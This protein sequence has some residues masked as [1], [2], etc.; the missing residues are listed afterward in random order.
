MERSWR[1]FDPQLLVAAVALTAFGLAMIHSATRAAAATDPRLLDL[2]VARQAIYAAAALAV[3]PLL[4]RFDYRILGMAAPAIYAAAIGLLVVVLFL[5]PTIY[6]SRRWLDLPLIPIQ[7][8]EIA[9][10]ALAIML[11]KYLADQ[12][13]GIRRPLILATTL[14][15]AGVLAILVFLQP[16]A[17]TSLI[18]GAIWLGTVT[19][20]GARPL[21]LGAIVGASGVVLLL[22][23]GI[24]VRPYMLARLAASLNPTSD[25]L[26]VGYNILQ[27]EISVGSGGLLGKGYVQGTQTQLNFLRVQSTDFIFSVLGEELGFVGAIVLFALY[28]WLLMRG[29]RA[30]ML[31]RDEFGRFLAVGI[32]TLIL[33]QA[34]LN[35]SVNVRLL[36]VTGVPLPF[37][38]YGGSSLVTLLLCVGILESIVVRHKKLE[39]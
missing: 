23:Q 7:P 33:A 6:G 31:A 8:S 4:T 20:A 38:S 25:P 32:V 13:E 12:R 5:A 22:L 26:G 17:G 30:A 3:I 29:L 21:H 15:I 35:I 2:P 28:I 1:H 18:F 9:K 10:L 34:F 16:D 14:A 36:P 24:I 11:A 39:F 37:I 19:M 27:S